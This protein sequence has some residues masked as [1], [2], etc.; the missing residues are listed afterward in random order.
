M[1]SITNIKPNITFQFCHYVI[2]VPSSSQFTQLSLLLLFLVPNSCFFV[3]FSCTTHLPISFP[4]QYHFTLSFS[5]FHSPSFYFPPTNN[6]LISNIPDIHLS[7]SLLPTKLLS[8]QLFLTFT[9]LSS[10]TQP[11]HLFCTYQIPISDGCYSSSWVT[12][13]LM[14]FSN[15]TILDKSLQII[16]SI[17]NVCTNNSPPKNQQNQP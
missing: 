16:S 3:S 10:P 7:T 2:Y 11:S 14:T 4:Q 5:L 6:N 8:L 15:D 1:S 13:M 9:P 12:L 17:F